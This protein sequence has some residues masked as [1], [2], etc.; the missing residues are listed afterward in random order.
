MMYE[1][2]YGF[3]P[4]KNTKDVTPSDDGEIQ[5]RSCTLSSFPEN[6]Y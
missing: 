1:Q 4:G 6:S 3:M 5:R 2:K